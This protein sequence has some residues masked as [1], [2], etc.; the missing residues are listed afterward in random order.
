[1]IL[2]ILWICLLTCL[3]C[4]GSSWA[5][6]WPAWRGADRTDVSTEL[7]F[8]VS[9]LSRARSWL[10]YPRSAGL[11]TRVLLWSTKMC[12]QWVLYKNDERLVCLDAA[13]GEVRWRMVITESVLEN[14]WGDGPRGTPT[15]D[16]EFVYAMAGN[17]TVVCAKAASGDLV[18]KISMQDLGGKVPYWG[19]S[20]S[21][22]VDGDQLICTPG[23]DDGALV[24]VN[25]ATGKKIWQSK[26][27]TD[28]ADY[29]SVIV[30]EHDDVKQY[31]QLTQKTLVG[32]AADDGRVLWSYPWPG[33]TAVVPTPIFRGGKSLCRLWVW[34]W[35]WSCE[36]DG[37]CGR[38]SLRK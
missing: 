13:T 27:F 32:I 10:G 2:R 3:I 28:P 20:E 23:G 25:K 34:R 26:D 4:R 30:A 36:V 14:G 7:D 31:I 17:G 5:E 18:W 29:S 38:R 8:L 1:M 37:W 33:R 11:A 6:N 22:L 16:G 19:Y 9:G 21:V 15:V 24:A 35:M 12:T